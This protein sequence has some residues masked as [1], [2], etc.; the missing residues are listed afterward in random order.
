MLNT[1]LKRYP[2]SFPIVFLVLC[3]ILPYWKLL[4][5]QGIIITDDIFVSDIMNEG[6]PDRALLGRIIASGQ[7]PTW[8]PQVFGGL[9]FLALGS[10]GVCYPINIILFG[11]LNPYTALNV[12]I[13]LTLIIAA[14]GMF[15]YARE[16]GANIPGALIAGIS[17]AFCGFMVSHL[18]HLSMVGSVCWFPWGLLALERACRSGSGSV[19]HSFL[20]F[21]LLFAMQILSGFFQ[22]AYYSFLVYVPYFMFRMVTAPQASGS[23]K[24][25]TIVPSLRKRLIGVVKHHKLIW[26]AAS[27]AVAAGINAIQILPTYESVSLSQRSGGVTFEYASSYAYNPSNIKTFVYPYVNGDISDAS[28]KA[29]S[30]FWED[31]GYAGLFVFLLALYGVFT[32]WKSGYVKF[33]SITAAVAYLLVLGPNTPVYELVFNIIPGMKFFRFP[34]R[35]LFI[36]DACLAI[37]A[38]LGTTRLLERFGKKKSNTTNLGWLLVAFVLVDLVYFQLRQNPIVDMKAWKTPP[39][40]AQILQK[41]TTLFRIYSPGSNEAHKAAFAKAKGW[42]G[43]LQ[44]YIDQRE[45]LQ[46]SSH[47]LYGFSTADGYAQ[48]TP[49]YVVDIWGDQNR[50]GLIYETAKLLPQG[51]MPTSAFMNILNMN[52]VK[53]VLAPWPFVGTSVELVDTVGGVYLYRNP[54]YLPRAFCVGSFVLSKSDDQTKRLLRSEDFRPSEQAILNETPELLPETNHSATAVVEHYGTNEVIVRV[55][56]KH[57]VLLV[58]SDTY[59]PGWKAEVDGRETKVLRANHNQRAASVPQGEH[60]VRFAFESAAIQWG[61]G[62]TFAT[63]LL[64]A[65]GMVIVRN[66]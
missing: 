43:D 20:W 25:K 21:G 10:A 11:L 50:G 31:Y 16:I 4:T 22:T 53:Y 26:L 19:A 12:T 49:N 35:F 62:I 1:L 61:A 29:D 40:T 60:V 64:M 37:L 14:F 52:N 32:G 51:F 65:I 28:Y 27:L 63:M 5:M 38:A 56:A 57:N 45:F 42:N 7:L 55:T 13:L 24:Q 33:F 48:L 54:D 46:P 2:V 23:T 17:F 59:Y 9:P 15:L 44:P 30:I 47:L 36:V 18:R 34:T 6:F 3:I 8:C 41:D 58:L 66:K 39:R